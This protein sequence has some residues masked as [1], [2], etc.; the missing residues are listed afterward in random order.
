MKTRSDHLP[1]LLSALLFIP[2]G[3][4]LLGIAFVMAVT[5]LASLFTGGPVQPQQTIFAAGYTFTGSLLFVAAF[6]VLQKYLRKPAADRVVSG[7]LRTGQILLLVLLASACLLIGYWIGAQESLNWLVLPVLTVPAIVLPLGILLA[8][9]A[10]RLPFGERWQTWSIL[11][12]AMTLGPLLLFALEIVAALFVFAGAVGYVLTRPDLILELQQLSDQFMIL[13]PQPDMEA[14]VELLSP[15]LT[16]PAV[17]G[18]TLLYIAV[19]VPAIE[20]VFKPIG[21]WL[22]A[23]RIDS[24]AQGFALGALSGAGYA[25]VET[26]GISGQQA[27]DWAGLLASRVGTGLLHI[28]TSALMGAAIVLAWRER[29]YLRLLGTYLLAVLLHGLWNALAVLFTFSTLGEFLDE[30]GRIAEWQ[31]PATVAMVSLAAALFVI[32]ILSNRRLRAKE[33]PPQDASL[34]PGE[35]EAD[36][37]M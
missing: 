6:F 31:T 35:I 16:R 7:T 27:G 17:I 1:S 8:L 28:T 15:L 29:R 30:P 13:G 18:T 37:I 19:L 9:G 5:A 12:L 34:P 4:L 33:E 14:A 10:R 3:L 36:R 21:V 32:L 23:R 25:L 22:F 20:E 26:V 24:A 11:G 2:G